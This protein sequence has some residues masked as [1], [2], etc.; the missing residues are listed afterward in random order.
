MVPSVAA[1]SPPTADRLACVQAF[2][3]SIPSYVA[4][5]WVLP[6][7]PRSL[8][9]T[10]PAT[11]ERLGVLPLAAAA[12]VDR[13]AAAARAAFPAWRETPPVERA[14]CLFRLKFLLEQHA[15]E[16]ARIVTEENGKTLSEARGSVR[17]G[18]ENL[19]HACGIPSLMMGQ[20]L[21]DIARGVD[22][23]TIRQ[24]LGVFAAIT[25]FNFPA[26]VPLWFW[27]YAVATGNTIIVKPSEQVPLSQ[28]RIFELAHEAGFPAG[29]LNLLHGDREAVDALLAHRDIVGISFV[30]SS[31]VA[32]HIYRTAADHGKR[33]QAL[34][35]AKNHI[36]V[37]PDAPVD[38]AVEGVVSSVYGCAGQRCLAGSVLVAVDRAHE[39]LR[40]RVAAAARSLRL[41]YGLD[42]D[43]DMGPVV[44]ARHRQRVERFIEEGVKEGA[45]LVV[46]G[47]G[48]RVDTYPR[49]Q[50]VGPTLF[51]QVQPAMTIGREEIFGPV[52]SVTRAANLDEAI[53]L[54]HKSGYANATSIF[55]SSGRAA[56]EFRYRVGVS[57]IGVN[58]GVAAPMAFFPFGG[59]KGSFFGDLKAHGHD[60][61]EFYTDKK[62]VISRW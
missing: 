40:E 9:I 34:G 30:G 48:A 46:D 49:G 25:P 26:M 6:D 57:M 42:A 23:E 17:R 7:S 21:E 18:I 37:L 14:R 53:E 45:K 58:I 50:W 39:A 5:E 52:L 32:R 29:V 4:G 15:D 19:E 28:T 3:G 11:A 31:A 61:I 36:V 38:A 10:N 33:V 13:A 47:R 12:D 8:E 59:T 2:R 60:A 1:S 51:E 55:T 20:T 35:G 22:C 16:L 43:T 41:G 27:P 24:P 62:V 54:V 44:S 56:R